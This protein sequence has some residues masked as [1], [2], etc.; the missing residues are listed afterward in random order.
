MSS[1]VNND[2][3]GV[4]G[5]QP[6]AD[7]HAVNVDSTPNVETNVVE[8]SEDS[9][10]IIDVDLNGKLNEPEHA[11]RQSSRSNKGAPLR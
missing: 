9:D 2:V 3:D 8:P 7:D 6:S 1:I 11:I 10:V 5:V 4:V